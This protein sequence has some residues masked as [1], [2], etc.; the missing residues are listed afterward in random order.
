MTVILIFLTIV[1]LI[2]FFFREVVLTSL[3]SPASSWDGWPI[4]PI[5]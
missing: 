1:V 3:H 2:I 4:G 5:S